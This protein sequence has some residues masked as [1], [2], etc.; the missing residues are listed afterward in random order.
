MLAAILR[1]SSRTHQISERSV[2]TAL[3][4]CEHGI[5]CWLAARSARVRAPFEVRQHRGGQP[6]NVLP[7]SHAVRT[8]RKRATGR[9][10][11]AAPAIGPGAPPPRPPA[12]VSSGCSTAANVDS[13]P[14]GADP[15]CTHNGSHIGGHESGGTLPTITDT[16]G[17][18]TL[19]KRDYSASR[20]GV[21]SLQ[22]TIGR[23]AKRRLTRQMSNVEMSPEW[24]LVKPSRICGVCA[25]RSRTG[26]TSLQ[27]TIGRLAKR[28]LARQMSNVEM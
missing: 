12:W 22:S 2:F 1:C 27:S 17:R 3:A 4:Y 20:T 19:S 14:G 21:T 25:G 5:D 7:A 11:R 10:S 18:E 16:R 23:L 13:T 6:G 8:Q 15:G 9:V 28:R 26:V 24:Q